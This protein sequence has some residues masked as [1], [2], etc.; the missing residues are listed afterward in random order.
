M[1]AGSTMSAV[2]FRTAVARS[3]EV[4]A[5]DAASEAR[6]RTGRRGALVRAGPL[7]LARL[8]A[9]GANIETLPITFSPRGERATQ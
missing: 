9:A 1:F 6:Q 7:A 5:S 4:I 2:L 3:R 8:P